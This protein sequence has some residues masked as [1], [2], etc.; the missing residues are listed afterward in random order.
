MQGASRCQGTYSIALGWDAGGANEGPD[1][2]ALASVLQGTGMGDASLPPLYVVI[3]HWAKTAS[4]TY[5]NQAPEKQGSS[6]CPN[7][8][9]SWQ[10]EFCLTAGALFGSEVLELKPF[11]VLYTLWH[12]KFDL[13]LWR[14][15]FHFHMVP[16]DGLCFTLF[17]IIPAYNF[18]WR[19]LIGWLSTKFRTTWVSPLL[20]AVQTTTVSTAALKERVAAAGA[21]VWGRNVPEASPLWL[22]ERLKGWE[23]PWEPSWTI[24]CVQTWYGPWILYIYIEKVQ[25]TTIWV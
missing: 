23:N 6:S 8:S 14:L 12:A 20:P 19:I 3:Q 22:S 25:V 16:L 21:A 1:Q 9:P 18:V 15:T 7:S 4:W 5:E 24:K 13:P 10:P 2:V 17:Q 11:D